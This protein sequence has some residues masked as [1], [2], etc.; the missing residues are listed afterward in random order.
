MRSAMNQ[1]SGNRSV[2]RWNLRSPG[3]AMAVLVTLGVMLAAPGLVATVM[4]EATPVAPDTGA[5]TAP[6]TTASSR[7][8]S[9]ANP[10]PTSFP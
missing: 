5:A 6:A 8:S 3:L 4:A 2:G 1:L 7:S 10:P 9:P